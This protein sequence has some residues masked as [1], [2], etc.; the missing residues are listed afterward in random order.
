MAQIATQ[1]KTP[2]LRNRRRIRVSPRASRQ[3]ESA[4][5]WWT[6]NRSDDPSLLQAEVDRVFPL[7]SSQPG[8]GLLTPKGKIKGLRRI[9]L[10]RTRYYLYYRT[11]R[12]TVDVLA[13]WHSSRG[14]DPF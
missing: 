3:I 9:H 7:I 8:I 2:R 1:P 12:S 14:S 13:F 6:R 5:V 4:S 10:S 11:R